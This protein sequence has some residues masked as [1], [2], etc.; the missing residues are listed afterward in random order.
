[1]LDGAVDSPDTGAVFR[2][3]ETLDR[4]GDESSTSKEKKGGGVRSRPGKYPYA[5]AGDAVLACA[6]TAKRGRA[7]D[8]LELAA[9]IGAT[10]MVG[11][12]CMPSLIMVACAA[13][14]AILVRSSSI[15]GGGGNF[16]SF[17]LQIGRAH[18]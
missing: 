1:M 10:L 16:S 5:G 14:W 13:A 4:S 3:M 7:A 9:C 18:V 8:G 6:S 17:A 11:A 2:S 12:G 15:G